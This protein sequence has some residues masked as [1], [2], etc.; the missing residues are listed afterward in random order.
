[1]DSGVTKKAVSRRD[2][3]SFCTS[4]DIK[5]RQLL[6]QLSKVIHVPPN[7]IIFKQGEPSESLYIINKGVVEVFVQN[8]ENNKTQSLGYL[9]R[10]DC[11]GEI[12]LLTS[13]PRSASVRSCEECSLQY[14]SEENFYRLIDQ[15]PSFFHYL[16]VILAERLQKTSYMAFLNSNCLD[17]SGNLLNFDLV[18]VFQTIGHS[19]KTGELR[20]RDETSRELGKFSFR[21]GSPTHAQWAHLHGI[22]AIWELFLHPELNGTFAFYIDSIPSDE[23]V[24]QDKISSTEVLMNAL[25]MRDEFPALAE[26]V[27]KYPGV[28]SAKADVASMDDESLQPVAQAVLD[29]LKATPAPAMDI[30]PLMPYSEFHIFK[31]VSEMAAKGQIG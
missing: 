16:S 2:F 19:S 9:S 24:I 7:V 26:E 29:F 25:Q 1:M 3:F 6:G 8:T 4:L 31:V 30:H 15:V 13:V 28:L 17:L 27:E 10:G 11:L 12:G 20:I 14:F 23:D 18:T 22:H 5:K 21:A